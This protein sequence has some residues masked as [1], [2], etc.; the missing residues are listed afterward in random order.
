MSSILTREQKVMVRANH[1]G[2]IHNAY[3]DAVDLL[4]LVIDPI[5]EL[6]GEDLYLPNVKQRDAL[7][8]AIAKCGEMRDAVH[9]L[10]D[11]LV[12]VRDS[13]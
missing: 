11:Y 10:R 2:H 12:G 3:S 1:F 5:G 4:N 9:D 13:L 7:N 6:G 8:E